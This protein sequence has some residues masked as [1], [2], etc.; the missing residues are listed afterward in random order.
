MIPQD[1]MNRMEGMLS[2]EEYQEFMSGY[3]NDKYQSLRINSLKVRR[4]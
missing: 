2:Q 3:D 4:E 1:F